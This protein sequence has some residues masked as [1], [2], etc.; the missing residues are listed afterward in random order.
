MLA[1]GADKQSGTWLVV[2]IGTNGEIVLVSKS[3]LLTCSTAAGPAFEGGG[4]ESGMRAAEGAI[5]SVTIDNDVQFS[6]IGAKEPLGICG[7][8]LVDVV[9]EMVRTGIV[10]DNGWIKSPEECPR[11]LS[12]LVLN[13][14]RDDKK[15][16]SFR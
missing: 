11:E 6:V 12:P 14:I 8:G 10:K 16:R 13:R 7:S 2:D 5:C 4:I 9:S 1:T 3:R 15:G